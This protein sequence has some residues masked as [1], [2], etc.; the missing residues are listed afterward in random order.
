[1]T[2]SRFTSFTWIHVLTFHAVPLPRSKTKMP[3]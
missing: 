2:L 3:P 1:M